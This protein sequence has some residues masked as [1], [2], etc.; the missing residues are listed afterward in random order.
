MHSHGNL[1]ELFFFCQ[2]CWKPK[3]LRVK[4]KKEEQN[5]L[6]KCGIADPNNCNSFLQDSFRCGSDNKTLTENA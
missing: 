4:N 2:Y 6:T 5:S 1:Q 3:F